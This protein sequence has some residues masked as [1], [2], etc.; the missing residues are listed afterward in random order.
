MST[1]LQLQFF[2]V[3][4]VNYSVVIVK[5]KC[6]THNITNRKRL[7]W[8]KLI[9]PYNLFFIVSVFH[10]TSRK[11]SQRDVEAPETFESLG[12]FKVSAIISEAATS[13][14]GLVLDKIL[15]VSVSAQ[16]VSCT[17]LKLMLPFF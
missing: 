11:T 7:P 8:C 14:L 6:K 13:R 4:A 5:I 15:N 16:K 17:F 2:M 1:A 9:N 12:S 10:H 3:Q